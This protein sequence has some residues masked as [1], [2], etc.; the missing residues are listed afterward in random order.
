MFTYKPA[1]TSKKEREKWRVER[2]NNQPESKCIIIIA[3]HIGGI[4][5]GLMAY[6]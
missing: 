6:T 2:N 3:D 5:M 1:K 4:L